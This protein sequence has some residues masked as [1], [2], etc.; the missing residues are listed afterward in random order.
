LAALLFTAF[1]C[2]SC[3]TTDPYIPV[4]ADVDREEFAQAAGVLDSKKESIYRNKDRVLYFLDRG[5]LTHYAGDYKESSVSL[6]EGER[7][8]EENFAVSIS[9]EAGT[10]ML[11]DLSR[12]Y[13]GEDY[14]D[15]Y[16][17]VFNALNYY[18]QGDMDEA[19]VEIRRMNNKLRNL[20]VKYGTMMSAVQKAALE[21]GTEIPKK[22]GDPIKFENSALAR[23]LGML[24][25][26]ANGDMDDAR[27][28]RDQLKL[29]FAAAPKIYTHPVPSSL[30]D[31]LE[32]PA[33][34]ARLNVLAFA[35]RT[36]VKI[37]EVI[38]IPLG[39]NWIKIAL[40]V[41]QAR[42]SVIT[43]IEVVFD[44]GEHFSLELLEDM[45]AVA[46]ATFE[47]KRDLI[48]ARSIIRATI[49]GVSAAAFDSMAD[50]SKNRDNAA[51]FSL[52]SLGTQIFAEASERADLRVSRYFPGNAYVGA[53]TVKPGRYS[54]FVYYYAGSKTA[55][56]RRFED[57]SIQQNV[58]NLMEVV[59][60]K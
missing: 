18:H 37:E 5:M 43:S 50:N 26:R 8:I 13:D 21:N 36:P 28:D 39:S 44:G 56:A 25:Y 1:V 33:G 51:L 34:M 38:R 14:E 48:Y 22:S 3:V 24:F 16:L 12:E 52:L 32:I 45:G 46:A 30:N 60:L 49:K 27:I 23:Y 31:E 47:R 4:D 10:L 57:V 59:C 35:G 2:I 55:A 9:Q 6:G 17:N 41:M 29:A 58:L 53:L 42:P 19:L 15:V 11:N 20:S 54:F 40:P 7:A